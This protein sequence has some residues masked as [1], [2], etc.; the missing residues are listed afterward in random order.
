MSETS[1]SNSGDFDDS[2]LCGEGR[3][4]STGQHTSSRKQSVGPPK[5]AQDSKKS[6]APHPLSKSLKKE[7]ARNIPDDMY[8]EVIEMDKEQ[9]PDIGLEE[10][11]VELAN[12]ESEWHCPISDFDDQAAVS[13]E[14]T[15]ESVPC[16]IESNAKSRKSKKPSR[17]V[18]SFETKRSEPT[19]KV[20]YGLSNQD[21]L[22]DASSLSSPAPIPMTCRGQEQDLSPGS[23]LPSQLEALAN[24]RSDGML[25][26][27]EFSLAKKAILDPRATSLRQRIRGHFTK[28]KDLEIARADQDKYSVLDPVRNSAPAPLSRQGPAHFYLSSHFF[29]QIHSVSIQP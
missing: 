3:R 29:L 16:S 22:S 20:Q 12:R 25:S 24:L 9:H 1:D 8:Q 18:K 13:E 26:D 10:L 21:S 23:D 15:L 7:T 27:A 6:K 4:S 5:T 2:K 19:R 28:P 14:S 17:K 11:F